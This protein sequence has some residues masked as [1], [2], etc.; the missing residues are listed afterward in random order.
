MGLKN[1][2]NHPKIKNLSKFK[3]V[4]LDV[5]KVIKHLI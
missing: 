3:Y 5:F 1:T 2:K 4:I